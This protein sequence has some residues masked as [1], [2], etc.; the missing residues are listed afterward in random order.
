MPLTTEQFKDIIGN[1]F[2][3]ERSKVFTEVSTGKYP[4]S[5]ALCLLKSKSNTYAQARYLGDEVFQFIGN[6][7][8]DIVA[9]VELEEK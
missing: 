8:M 7:L 5:G 3:E 9:W 6:Y 4:K 2:I 1:I